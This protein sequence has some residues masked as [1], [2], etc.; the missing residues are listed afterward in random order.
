[1]CGV[2]GFHP[3]LVK[4]QLYVLR[5]KQIGFAGGWGGREVFTTNRQAGMFW[6]DR[7]VLHLAILQLCALVKICSTAHSKRVNFTVRK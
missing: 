1:M 5:T 6:G 3:G 2:S 4:G 7:N